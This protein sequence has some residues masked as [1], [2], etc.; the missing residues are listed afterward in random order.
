MIDTKTGPSKSGWACFWIFNR[1]FIVTEGVKKWETRAAGLCRAGSAMKG[2][3]W[4]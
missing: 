1:T 2:K 4:G 3:R